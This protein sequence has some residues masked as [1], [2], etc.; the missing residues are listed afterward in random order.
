MFQPNNVQLM[1][2]RGTRLLELSRPDEARLDFESAVKLR[3]KDA[4]LWRQRGQIEAD[5]GDPGQAAA[6]FA[7][8]LDLLP[9]GELWNAPRSRA[10]LELAEQDKVIA[11]LNELRPKDGLLQVG[12]ARLHARARSVGRS[13]EG[14]KAVIESRPP[15]EEWYE[16]ASFQL[17]SGDE[18][19]Y[20]MTCQ[21]LIEL[22]KESK[23]SYAQFSLA[24][25]CILVPQSPA[26]SAELVKTAEAGAAKQTSAWLIHVLAAAHF[27]AGQYPEA[28]K[29]LAESEAASWGGRGQSQNALLRALIHA[30]Q[31]EVDQVRASLKKGIELME[32]DIAASPN[33]LALA[34]PDW[35]EFQILRREAE[36]LIGP[37]TNND[38]K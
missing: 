25:A 1:L 32:R 28:L 22:L 13:G 38:A 34:N 16:L 5:V 26:D 7:Q 19:G 11:K 4:Q 8:F 36:T 2:A 35:Y 20:R 29:R 17:L 31:G 37:T 24:R 3:P 33:R 30:K 12:R 27:R 18:A 14:A 23:D 6:A 9:Q 21:R 10:S 15:S